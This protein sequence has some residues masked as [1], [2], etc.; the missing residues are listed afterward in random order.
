MDVDGHVEQMALGLGS[1]LRDIEMAQARWDRFVSEPGEPP[2]AE[3][4]SASPAEEVRT[5][6]TDLVLRALRAGVDPVNHGILAGLLED[7]GSASLASLI[8][9]TGLPRLA[10]TERLNELAQVGLVAYSPESR[11]ARATALTEAF[12]GI[13]AEVRDRLMRNM[14]SR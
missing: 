2:A 12:L 7:E 4:L 14:G 13:V 6:A 9:R 8:G 5:L 11:G 1:R 10:L 3:G